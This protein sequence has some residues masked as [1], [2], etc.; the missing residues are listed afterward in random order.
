MAA[1]ADA[2]AVHH[3]L[4]ALAWR[5]GAALGVAAGGHPD[6]RNRLDPAGFRI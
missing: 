2:H 1:P 3:T 6:A 4:H 5:L